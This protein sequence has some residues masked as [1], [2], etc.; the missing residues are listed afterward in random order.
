MSPMNNHPVLTNALFKQYLSLQQ[1]KFR[2]LERMY[3]VEGVRLCEE[4]LASDVQV[5]A[6]LIDAN[7][8]NQSERLEQ[9]IAFARIR[10]IPIY[11]LVEK[12]FE[13]I[14]TTENSQGVFAVARFN[15]LPF[16]RLSKTVNGSPVILLDAISDPGNL[17][18][19]IRTAAW[20]SC[21]AA[22]IGERSVNIYNPKTVRATM[23][24]M[25][26]VPIAIEVNLTSAINLLKQRNYTI[27][28]TAIEHAENIANIK[29][30]PKSAL[31]FGNEAH[32][33]TIDLH[34]L[35]DK[36]IMI[37]GGTIESLSVSVA[38]GIVM[39]CERLQKE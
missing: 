28:S 13:L 26:R 18:T 32:G 11:T 9:L 37:P 20:F 8:I 39:A 12:Q 36:Q 35:A 23:G 16:E 25:F 19:I 10:E 4:L 31:L 3:L 6:I 24:G 30:S 27:Y 22:F 15:N 38:A 2:E 1:K 29:F 34:G 14:A 17:G 7:G 5:E 33:V 21:A